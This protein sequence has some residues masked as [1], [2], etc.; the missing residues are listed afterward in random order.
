VIFIRA[1]NVGGAKLPMVELR[2]IAAGIGATEVSTHLA[3]GNLL[4]HLPAPDR[5]LASGPASPHDFDRALETAIQQR[6]GF[7]REVISR[8]PAELSAAL[9]AYPFPVTRPDRS[10]I[11]LL[12]A[13]PTP[14]GVQA[15]TKLTFGDDQWQLIGTDVHL[16]YQDG[17]GSSKLTAALLARKLGVQGT[18]RNLNTLT[19]LVELA[20]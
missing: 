17:A 16:R 3:S 7:F 5:I 6:F 8:S 19:K 15:L 12:T 2:E 18:S 10:F 4:C 14:A 9:R 1:V 20:S 11:H 13:E